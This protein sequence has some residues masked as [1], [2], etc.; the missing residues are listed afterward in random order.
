[1]LREQLISCLVAVMF[2]M[3]LAA[4]DSP[5]TVKAYVQDAR[6]VLLLHFDGD[7]VDASGLKHE[8]AGTVTE[9][10][11]GVCGKAAVWQGNGTKISHAQAALGQKWA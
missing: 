11:D 2:A 7:S 5:E 3:N 9:W 1:M 4:A 8:L 6:T 10:R